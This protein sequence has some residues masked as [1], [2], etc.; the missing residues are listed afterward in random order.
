MQKWFL[1]ISSHLSFSYM[2]TT[3]AEPHPPPLPPGREA[4]LSAAFQGWPLFACLSLHHVNCRPRLEPLLVP[5]LSPPSPPEAA[6]APSSSGPSV[7]PA[8]ASKRLSVAATTSRPNTASAPADAAAAG[9]DVG[10]H[11]CRGGICS[12]WCCGSAPVLGLDWCASCSC[13]RREGVRGVRVAACCG[14]GIGGVG[15]ALAAVVPAAAHSKHGRHMVLPP[16]HR[17][18]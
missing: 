10:A 2:S 9:R 3:L 5:L 14:V 18:S 11:S 12:V 4:D 7:P 15:P 6:I 1:S 16:L 17:G 13:C 8:A